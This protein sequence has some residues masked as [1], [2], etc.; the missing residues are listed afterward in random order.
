MKSDIEN[1]MTGLRERPTKKHPEECDYHMT[2]I[3]KKL[4]PK[5]KWANNEY[6]VDERDKFLHTCLGK[7][8]RPDFFCRELGYV[9]EIDG[10]SKRSRG[11]YSNASQIVLDD[12]RNEAYMKAGYHV[13]RIPSW[14]Q[15]DK[16][17][18]AYY[19]HIFYDKDLYP[20]VHEHGFAHPDIAL[21]ADFCE[22]GI[23]RFE[24]ELLEYPISV[25][26]KI[27]DTLK[28]RIV[29]LENEGYS[30]ENAKKLVLPEKLYYL[31]DI[32]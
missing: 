26:N 27:I 20:A 2:S 23:T 1:F 12:M 31:L 22:L 13:I 10:D 4:F 29:N 3:L 21:P 28:A 9:V 16:D 6:I 25:K 30:S 7:K 5:N 18:I 11:H 14:I 32:K 15:L 8:I 17:M 24:K 19:F